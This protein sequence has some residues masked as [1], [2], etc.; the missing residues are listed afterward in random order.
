MF[1]TNPADF[2]NSRVGEGPTSEPRKPSPPVSYWVVCLFAALAVALASFFGVSA[3]SS[4]PPFSAQAAL[5][6]ALEDF[7]FSQELNSVEM[8]NGQTNVSVSWKGGKPGW[9]STGRYE[10]VL[11]LTGPLPDHVL[12]AAEMSEHNTFL[13][14]FKQH[15]M[16]SAVVT[17]VIEVSREHGAWTVSGLPPVEVFFAERERAF[18][19]KG[20]V[21]GV[22]FQST[23]GAFNGRD[24]YYSVIRNTNL[25]F[26]L[27]SSILA[28]VIAAGLVAQ[29]TEKSFVIRVLAASAIASAS[30]TAVH[31]FFSLPGLG[32]LTG[33]TFG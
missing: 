22:V 21:N 28:L 30:L 4:A 24:G 26:E 19:T 29:F 32:F 15:R 6:D 17:K 27:V 13:S 14:L 8:F 25:Q 12:S 11:T 9:R 33:I 10:A 1:T 5:F 16:T 7:A 18:L 3:L 2:L 20:T 31:C 23:Q